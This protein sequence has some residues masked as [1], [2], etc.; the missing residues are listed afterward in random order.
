MR[1]TPQEEAGAWGRQPPTR[2]LLNTCTLIS[3]VKMLTIAGTF[4]PLHLEQA[5]EDIFSITSLPQ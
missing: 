2:S 5:S 1:P 4:G 3:S